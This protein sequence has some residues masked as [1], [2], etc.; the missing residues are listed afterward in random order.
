MSN[1]TDETEIEVE[2]EEV[3]LSPKELKKLEKERK[4][5]E[6]EAAKEAKRIQS[7][8]EKTARELRK[9]LSRYAQDEKFA[10]AVGTAIP[11]YWNGYYD[12]ETADE[13]DANESFRF[14]DWFTY[15]YDLG[16]GQR[17]IDSF[18]ADMREELT[19]YQ[20]EMVAIW[21]NARPSG[22][23]EFLDYDPFSQK[24]KL[25]D[26]FSDEEL[27][28]YTTAGTGNAVKG[29][30]LLLRPIEVGER[31]EFSTL[32]A[33]IPQAE[34]DGLAEKMAAAKE[35]YL[36][37]NP[38]ATHEQFLRA[39]NHLLVHHAIAK[40]EE[41]E[42]YPVARLNPR[43]VDTKMRSAAK[44]VTKKLKRRK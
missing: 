37:E 43:R 14:F 3:E 25:K 8:K 28:V 40:S 19:E 13:M 4:K 23:Y 7:Q 34:V 21:Q 17:L 10:T 26:F 2:N 9:M 24:F 38:D 27:I 5:Q 32:G 20:E 36:A 31:L 15:D 6:R 41:N 35:A 11:L 42:R 16:D 33:Y 1:A 12:L 29:D 39:N 18:G 22:A 30:V 44:K